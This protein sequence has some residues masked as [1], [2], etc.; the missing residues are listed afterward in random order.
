MQVWNWL[1]NLFDY[2]IICQR[3]NFEK[4]SER[5]HIALHS[6]GV[7]DYVLLIG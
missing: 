2:S 7:V 6:N 4:A 3:M 1:V 5:K